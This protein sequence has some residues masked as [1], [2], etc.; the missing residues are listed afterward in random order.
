MP[1]KISCDPSFSVDEF[2]G[3]SL[4]V[5]YEIRDWKIRS[6]AYQNMDVVRHGVDLNQLLFPVRDDAGDVFVEFSFVLFGDKRLSSF[7]GKYNVYVELAIGVC[8]RSILLT[9][10]GIYYGISIDQ[11]SDEMRSN[12]RGLVDLLV[13]DV[14]VKFPVEVVV[15]AVHLG[16]E[17]ADAGI[18]IRVYIAEALI[19]V[20]AKIVYTLI[21]IAESLVHMGVKIDYPLVK[22][23]NSIVH[24][25]EARIHIG[26][27]IV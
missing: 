15:F 10:H 22:I 4:D 12:S 1:C 26:V 23:A 19:H 8:H 24:I 5:P 3:I 2:R 16:S 25:A 11:G 9:F 27:K 7:D 21:H 13:G 14:G 18:N 6:D 17:V 20:G